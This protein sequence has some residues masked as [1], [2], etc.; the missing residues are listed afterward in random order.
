MKR[1]IISILFLITFL[2]GTQAQSGDAI[3]PLKFRQAQ[4]AYENGNYYEA[5]QLSMDASK[6][7]T[8]QTLYLYLKSIHKTYLENKEATGGGY[9]YK[10][11]KNFTL[12]SFLSGHLL[13]LID[14]KT[15][16]ADKYADIL[17][18]QQYFQQMEKKYEYQKDRTP[19]NA[20]IFLN[21]C[22]KKFGKNMVVKEAAYSWENPLTSSCKQS[23]FQLDSPYL[24]L[25]LYNVKTSAYGKGKK[26]YNRNTIYYKVDLLDLSKSTKVNAANTSFYNP[27]SKSWENGKDCTIEGQIAYENGARIMQHFYRRTDFITTVVYDNPS[28]QPEGTTANNEMQTLK[29]KSDTTGFPPRLSINS[30]WKKSAGGLNIFGYFDQTSQEYKDGNYNERI[31]EAIEYLADYYRKEKPKENTEEKKNGF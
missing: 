20:V 7:W 19:G 29:I 15:Y 16:P 27:E 31:K 13:E 17:A 2:P 10:T 4:E 3:D 8:T 23:A 24:K 6:N 26:T 11:Y 5:A 22:L 28:K 21:D 18:A 25:V 30:Q 9:F 12:F 14:P 1:I